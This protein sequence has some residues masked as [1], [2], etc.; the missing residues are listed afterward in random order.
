MP[1]LNWYG[2]R[3]NTVAI[4]DQHPLFLINWRPY[5]ISR[6]HLGILRLTDILLKVVSYYV[7]TRGMFIILVPQDLSK[8][9]T[10]LSIESPERL[11]MYVWVASFVTGVCIARDSCIIGGDIV[12]STIHW[13]FCRAPF[14]FPGPCGSAGKSL[15]QKCSFNRSITVLHNGGCDRKQLGGLGVRYCTYECAGAL[16]T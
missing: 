8:S 4:Y 11:D 7:I 2:C 13:S 14:P 10:K 15:S 16:G 5:F 9:E 6:T 1:S 3:R 12:Y